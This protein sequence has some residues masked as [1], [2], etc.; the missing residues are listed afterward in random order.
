MKRPD[1]TLMKEKVR[2]LEKQANILDNTLD[3]RNAQI[4]ALGDKISELENE[5][6][7]LKD[8]Y[9]AVEIDFRKSLLLYDRV[10]YMKTLQHLKSNI[11]G[12]PHTQDIP[13]QL[14][15]VLKNHK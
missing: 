3:I 1:M 12:L 2:L 13:G 15:V 7:Q 14:V 8:R 9:H 6:Q 11:T 4:Q 5:N 10:P